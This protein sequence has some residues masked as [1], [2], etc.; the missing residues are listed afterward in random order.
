MPTT[1]CLGS[2]WALDDTPY[3]ARA[4]AQAT[5]SART[6]RRLRQ[7]TVVTTE[8]SPDPAP[9]FKRRAGATPAATAIHDQGDMP[10]ARRHPKRFTLD[11]GTLDAVIF[12]LDGVLTDTAE[13]HFQA[14]SALFADL[15]AAC[16]RSSRQI[17]PPFD[18][19]DYDRLV[20]GEQRLDGLRHVLDNRGVTFPEGSPDDPPGLATVHALAADKDRRFTALLAELGP[21]P[22]P[23]SVQLL[24]QLSQAGVPLAVVSASRN[25]AQVLRQAGLDSLL[26]ARVDGLSAAALGLAGKP[27][28]ALF[29]EASRR[30]GADPTRTAIFEDATAGVE[31]GRRGGFSVVVGVDRVGQRRALL[32]AGAS[33][34]VEDLSDVRLQGR[35]PADDDW[36]LRY[37]G[38]EPEVVGRRESLCALANGL[39]GCRAAEPWASDDGV[40]YPGTY[41]ASIYDRAPEPVGDLVLETESLVNVPNWLP[42]SFRFDDGPWLDAGDSRITDQELVLDMRRGLLTRRCRVTPSGTGSLLLL[43]RRVVSME[44]PHL[45]GLELS[46]SSDGWAGAVEIR[47]A[48]AAVVTDETTEERL[49][50]HRHLEVVASGASGQLVPDLQPGPPEDVT[51][52]PTP[53]DGDGAGSLWLWARTRHSQVDIALASRVTIG[54]PQP[55]ELHP[56]A[57]AR[58]AP[59]RQPTLSWI[60]A[61]SSGGRVVVEKITAIHTSR[62]V[63]I[64][65]PCGAALRDAAAAPAFPALLKAHQDAWARLWSRIGSQMDDTDGSSQAVHLHCFHL[66]QV[67]SPHVRDLD[68]GLSARGL[69]GEGY[70]GHVFW[71]E[72][73]ALRVVNLHCPDVARQLLAYRERRLPAARRAAAAAHLPGARF[74]W[75][76]ASDGRDV[77]P[78]RLFNRGS[79]RWIPDRSRNQLHVGLAI[80]YN[81][82]QHYQA[83][84]DL[85]F[86]ATRGGEMVLEIALHFAAMASLGEDGAYHI[87]GVMGPDEFHDGYPWSAVAGVT[88]NAYTNVMTAWLMGRA[89]NMVTL[90]RES[91]RAQ[92]LERAGIGPAELE[93]FELL[94]HRLH[95]PFH[96]GVISQFADYERLEP[97]DLAAYRERYGN[98][99][100][101]DLLLESE[102]DSVNR[103]QVAKQADVLMLLYL[104]SGDELREVLGR[105]G[106]RFDNAAIET[107]IDYYEPR[108]TH[109]STLSPVVHAWVRA[110]ADRRASWQHFRRALRGDLDD[111][112]GGTAREGIHLGAMA[113]TIDLLERCYGGLE[114][115]GDALWF[116]PQLPTA[117]KW[118]AFPLIYRHHQLAVD[119]TPRRIRVQAGPGR[120]A[121]MTLVISGHPYQLQ[122][123]QTVEQELGA[124]IPAPPGAAGRRAPKPASAISS[125]G[126]DPI[127]TP[128]ANPLPQEDQRHGAN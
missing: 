96:Q 114:L 100:R 45:C 10:S 57:G 38:D 1:S 92:I 35:G 115:R 97:I 105:L 37:L 104:L 77:T 93:R 108:T 70:D 34:V 117:L 126:A 87:A 54:A 58:D 26:A 11:L 75:Q 81:V 109:G 66:F 24:W 2:W 40:R 48:L 56:L 68:L 29:L 98:I 60:G 78:T 85:D 15:F 16:A 52:T 30:L 106:H 50:P 72:L 22:F 18:R 83:T 122:P 8:G 49:L 71:D 44:D 23:G 51:A 12:D 69:H 73:F 39:I 90:L 19:D 43:E 88:D 67:A 124:P 46:L 42:V 120:A 82:L 13:L 103:Y 91:A 6:R 95:V 7:T 25:C 53:A 111:V 47:M 89:L 80:A 119:I 76:S 94:T 128:T 41:L 121:P 84:G 31:A 125:G 5:S 9:S 101:L 113:G 61:I 21:R 14:W 36:H 4:N 112:Q 110:R 123:G 27:D 28:P 79:Q 17:L 32:T 62:D 64:A 118:I 63:A 102:G 127:A 74:P 20:D 116:T 3:L 65:D 55:G 99:G 86:L 107:T 59:A 33:A